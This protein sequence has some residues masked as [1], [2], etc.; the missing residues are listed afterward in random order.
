MYQTACFCTALA[1]LSSLCGLQKSPHVQSCITFFSSF[2]SKAPQASEAATAVAEGLLTHLA[3][4]SAVADK[5]VR[6]H[7]CQLL[8]QLLSQLPASVLSD[9]AVLDSLTEALLERLQDKQPGIRAEAVRGLC[10]LAG[11]YEVSL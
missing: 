7:A 4:H 8:H 1:P 2:G 3:R 6:F 5:S 9:D 11:F 10:D